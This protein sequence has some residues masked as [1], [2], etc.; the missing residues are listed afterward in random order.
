M[1]LNKALPFIITHGRD[2]DLAMYICC[3]QKLSSN[4]KVLGN[5]TTM[6]HLVYVKQYY[7]SNNINIVQ[8]FQKYWFTGNKV[9]DQLIIKN[10]STP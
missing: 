3:F 7:L 10:A 4:F 6:L 5:I 8:N 2:L 9:I 1:A